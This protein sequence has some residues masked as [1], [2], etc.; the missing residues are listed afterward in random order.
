MA[1]AGTPREWTAF[2]KEGDPILGL[3]LFRDG[4]DAMH[5]AVKAGWPLAEFD[6]SWKVGKLAA[7]GDPTK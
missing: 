3:R 2:D 1:K 7:S 5:A 4:L 6:R